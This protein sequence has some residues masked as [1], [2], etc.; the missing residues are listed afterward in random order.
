MSSLIRRQRAP[1]GVG[2]CQRAKRARGG[3]EGAHR[4]ELVALHE[5]PAHRC[6]TCR[7]AASS[8]SHSLPVTRPRDTMTGCADNLV[9]QHNLREPAVWA[10]EVLLYLLQQACGA[11]TR[12]GLRAR[13]V[14]FCLA[15]DVGVRLAQGTGWVEIHDEDSVP[16]WRWLQ[17]HAYPRARSCHRRVTRKAPESNRLWA[18]NLALVCGFRFQ[19]CC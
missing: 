9:G 4:D 11:R 12:P 17:D 15:E 16:V 10:W 7:G 13:E 6:R 2:C 3:E 5:Q 19:M 1:T 8:A 14:Q 18:S